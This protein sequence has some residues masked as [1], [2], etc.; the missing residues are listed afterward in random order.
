MLRPFPSAVQALLGLATD[1]VHAF[2]PS[3]KPHTQHR[4]IYSCHELGNNNHSR[5][6]D[7]KHMALYLVGYWRK[8]S[9]TLLVAGI[10]RNTGVWVARTRP[11]T[12][13]F[14]DSKSNAAFRK[15]LPAAYFSAKH[16]TGHAAYA[17]SLWIF[18]FFGEQVSIER[19]RNKKRPTTVHNRE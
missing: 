14:A 4:A 8:L 16:A 12:V 9:M 17:A 5:E 7:M 11:P 3:C 19:P 13:S 1:M 6:R 10:E 2:H 18:L 15:R